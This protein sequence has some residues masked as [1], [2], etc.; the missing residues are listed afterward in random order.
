MK[1][2]LLNIKI[3]TRAILF[4]V[5]VF[6]GANLVNAQPQDAPQPRMTAVIYGNFGI[7]SGQTAHLHVVNA[8]LPD[9]VEAVGLEMQIIDRAGNI[10]AR[11]RTR[12][13]AGQTETISVNADLSR[14]EA[15]RLYLRAVVIFRHPQGRFTSKFIASSLEVTDNETNKVNMNI[16]PWSIFEFNPQPEPPAIIFQQP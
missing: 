7:V 15:E 2:K 14:R 6:M 13:A 4:G 16:P 10:V 5:V 8:H 1:N 3:L 12:L 11:K 9:S